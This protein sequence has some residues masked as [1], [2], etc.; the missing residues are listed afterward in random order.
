[1]RVKAEYK[2]AKRSKRNIKHAFV[3][4][5]CEKNFEKISVTNIIDRAGIS[6]GTFYAHFRDTDNLLQVITDEEFSAL[7]DYMMKLGFEKIFSEPKQFFSDVIAYFNEDIDYYKCLLLAKNNDIFLLELRKRLK[8]FVAK[9]IEQEADNGT[10][11]AY[12]V[13]LSTSV[14]SVLVSWLRGEIALSEEQ[15]VEFLASVVTAVSKEF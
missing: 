14:S 11:Q 3:E 7:F 1:M 4:L 8:D 12:I 13:L 5:L 6:R 10:T 9:S 2:S 15:I